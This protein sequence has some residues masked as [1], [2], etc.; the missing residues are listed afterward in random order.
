MVGV[1]SRASSSGRRNGTSKPHSR[2]TLAIS[3]SLVDNTVRVSSR[4]LRAAS[5]VQASSGLPS[6]GAM[7]FLG[8]P[9]DP[10]R[11][12]TIPKTRIA[13]AKTLFGLVVDVMQPFLPVR[14]ELRQLLCDAFGDVPVAIER[15]RPVSTVL[16]L[17]ANRGRDCVPLR[18]CMDHVAVRFT[19][20]LTIAHQYDRCSEIARIA[21]KTARISDRA[22][23]PGQNSQ[24]IFRH[25]I[26]KRAQP[27]RPRIF[28]E[29]ADCLAD[30]VRPGVDIRP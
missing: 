22:C 17:L 30:V 10:L 16:N 15:A 2:P 20:L 18:R 28:A 23:G 25:Q 3:W 11:A 12:V 1:S 26:S 9:F 13:I 8:I 14:S 7:F 6:S 29:D 19:P 4:E 24:V 5:A 21:H 27:A